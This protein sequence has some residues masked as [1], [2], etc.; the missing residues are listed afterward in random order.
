M[1]VNGW[2]KKYEG[3]PFAADHKHVTV[4]TIKMTRATADNLH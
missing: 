3:Q 1:T 2:N 4:R